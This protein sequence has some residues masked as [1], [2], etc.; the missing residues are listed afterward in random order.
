MGWVASDLNPRCRCCGKLL[1]EKVTRP[2]IIRCGRCK[3]PNTGEDRTA[4]VTTVLEADT[5]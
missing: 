4:P 3:T 2:W 5:Q 1:A